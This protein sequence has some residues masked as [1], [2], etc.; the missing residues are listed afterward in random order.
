MAARPGPFGIQPAKALLQEAGI[1][2]EDAATA[3]GV[4]REYVNMILNGS[5][6][7]SLPVA[8][9]LAELLGRPIEAIF[10]RKM[11]GLGRR[12]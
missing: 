1:A 6:R 3:V 12:R 2:Q 10:T 8:A 4:S 7:P 11:L 9:G 5:S